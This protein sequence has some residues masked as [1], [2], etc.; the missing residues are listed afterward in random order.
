MNKQMV[1]VTGLPRAGSTLLCQLLQH[2]PQISCDGHSSPLLQTLKGLRQHVT[3]NTFMMAQMDVDYDTT[4]QRIKGMY[5]G[6]IDGWFSHTEAP[7]VVDK[8]RD[9]LTQY[10]LIQSLRPDTKMLVCIRNPEQIYGSIESRHQK[11]VLLDFPDKLAD[12]SPYDRADKLFDAKGVIGSAMSGISA[13]QDFHPDEKNNIFFVIFEDL[14]VDPVRVMSNIFE[15]LSLD[16]I[17]L[18]PNALITRA[19]ESDSYYKFK[20][21][22]KTRSTISPPK[23]HV[24]PTRI[25]QDIRHHFAWFYRNFYPS[26]LEG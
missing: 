12:L 18:E 1:C 4:Y 25:K 9:W 16:D 17:T 14:V 10:D 13:L 24:I 8:N 3:D 6:I 26:A 22:H 5:Q 15:W 7:V 23:P 19:H 21:L 20:Y 11:S 2:H